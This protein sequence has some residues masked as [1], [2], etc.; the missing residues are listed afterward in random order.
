MQQSAHGCVFSKIAVTFTTESG[1]TVSS[2]FH[3][4][5]P[6][7]E[8]TTTCVPVLRLISDGVLPTYFQSSMVMSAPEG[9]ELNLHFT[10][11]LS[12]PGAAT[13][14][15]T[16][17]AVGGFCTGAATCGAGAGA[18]EFCGGATCGWGLAAAPEWG[19]ETS[20]INW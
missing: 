15:G 1:S 19:A 14:G 7:M 5:N 18:G 20:A 16:G 9:V 3:S 12:T 8:M 6:G 10:F 11:S 13:G 2:R 4:A 17:A